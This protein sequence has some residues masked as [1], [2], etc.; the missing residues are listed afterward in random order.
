[1]FVLFLTN[2]PINGQLN[3]PL[4]AVKPFYLIILESNMQFQTDH[5][6]HYFL[7][8]LGSFN[9]IEKLTLLLQ[10][11]RQIN[12]RSTYASKISSEDPTQNSVKHP[13]GFNTLA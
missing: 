12:K 10:Y 8:E 4:E 9:H 11:R 13:K 6:H 7:K 3:A 1:L 5:D 2:E